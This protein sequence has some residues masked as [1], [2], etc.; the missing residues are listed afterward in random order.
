MNKTERIQLVSEAEE[1][2]NRYCK[3]CFLYKYHKKEKGKR[4]AHRFCIT[5]CTVG[6]QIKKI[7]KKLSNMGSQVD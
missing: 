3:G 7:G 5:K 1:L 6:E 4:Y 2:M